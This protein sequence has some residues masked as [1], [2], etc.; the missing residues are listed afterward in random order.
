[1]KKDS[2]KDWFKF[3]V[4]RQSG[5]TPGVRGALRFYGTK[6]YIS[7]EESTASVSNWKSISLDED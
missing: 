5:G 7:T 1:M 2:L 4:W 6:L 3:Q